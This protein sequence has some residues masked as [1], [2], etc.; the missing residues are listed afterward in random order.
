[1]ALAQGLYEGREI[2]DRDQL[3]LITYMRTDS[4]RVSEEALDAVRVHIAETYG[5]DKL[6]KKPNRYRSK[7][8]AQDAH[9]AIRPTYL[10]LPPDAVASYLKPD[11]LKLYR[12]IWDRFVASQMLP[13]V[14]DVT[15]VDV[16]R[17]RCVLRAT[18]K[19]LK[20][21]GFLAVYQEVVGKLESAALPRALSP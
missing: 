4:T 15:R 10:D 13:A 21:P 2:G 20:R 14:F 18:G 5:E 17:G 1:M 16:E 8:G 6:P 9:E 7:K 19:V 11:E 12:L 3:G